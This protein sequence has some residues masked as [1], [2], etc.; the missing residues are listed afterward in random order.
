VSEP[1]APHQPDFTGERVIPGLVETDLWNEHLSRYAFASRLARRKRV[2]DMGCGAGYGSALLAES[3]WRVTGVDLAPDAVAY[4]REHYRAE[5]LTTLPA[6]CAALPFKPA[7]FDLVV[8]FEVIEHIADW[9][10]LI[11]EARRVLV[12]SGQFIVS[13]PNIHYYTETRRQSG[14]NRYHQHEFEF[15]EFSTELR[16]VF[17]QVAFFVQNHAEALVFQ[18]LERSC[19]ADLKL[20]PVTARAAESHFFVAVCA[21]AHQTGSPT[22]VYIPST[23]NVLR[24]REQHIEKLEGELQKKDHWLAEAQEEHGKL[25]AEHRGLVDMFRAQNEA[26]EKANEWAS[27]LNS[28]LEASGIRVLAL[29]QELEREQAAALATI[30]GYEAK[31]ADLDR[32]NQAKTQWAE[33]TSRNLKAKCDELA[34]CVEILHQV[35]A[36][37]D[38]RT[39]W[40]V[41]LQQ[42]VDA[43]EPQLK[44]LLD[45]MEMIRTSRWVRLGR[46][47]HIGPDL[48]QTSDTNEA[49]RGAQRS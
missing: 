39:Q 32:E 2:L 47:V 11:Q 1:D 42:Q 9:R 44:N 15:E 16:R 43:L 33:E 29:Q 41:R 13:T 34:R 4:A 18:P 8:A 36:E 26:L 22:F 10:N 30:T 5:N 28:D 48:T 21:A 3:A 23:A 20:E 6:S 31:I 35:E 7:S 12:P 27:K 46:M 49:N 45:R 14:P 40:G 19:S 25:L 37:R 24:E 17:P 38:E